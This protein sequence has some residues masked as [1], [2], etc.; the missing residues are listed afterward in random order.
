[1]GEW[2]YVPPAGA[3]PADAFHLS[4][5]P[6]GRFEAHFGRKDFA[7]QWESVGTL[8]AA[9]QMTDAKSGEVLQ[10]YECPLDDPTVTFENETTEYHVRR[11][12]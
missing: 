4:L 7:G 5:K 10:I 6:D 2:V 3:D 1:M 9:V 12:S 11:P 8:D